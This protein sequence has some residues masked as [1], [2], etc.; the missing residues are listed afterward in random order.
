MVNLNLIAS[1][2]PTQWRSMLPARTGLVSRLCPIKR[3]MP[4]TGGNYSLWITPLAMS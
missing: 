4:T 2:L 3:P 1:I